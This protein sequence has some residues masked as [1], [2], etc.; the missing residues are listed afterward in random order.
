MLYAELHLDY[1][2]TT[3]C[4]TELWYMD[5]GERILP[6]P[7]YKSIGVE[8]LYLYYVMD[9]VDVKCSVRQRLK[10]AVLQRRINQEE[11]ELNGKPICGVLVC[12][13]RICKAD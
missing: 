2:G 6:K 5:G 12:N 4:E 7:Q 10:N 11:L 9:S 3:L 1:Y 13:N 8:Y